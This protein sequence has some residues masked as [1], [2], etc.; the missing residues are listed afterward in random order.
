MDDPHQDY[1]E[2]PEPYRPDS[3]RFTFDV[4]KALR[5]VVS[6]RSAIPDTA[7]TSQTLGT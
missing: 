5:S 6:L 1:P 4:D 7:F 3:A 2:I